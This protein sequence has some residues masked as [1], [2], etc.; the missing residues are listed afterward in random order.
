MSLFEFGKDEVEVPEVQDPNAWEFLSDNEDF[1]T[2]R[3]RVPGGWIVRTQKNVY[4]GG[5][6]ALVFVPDV[7]HTW[8]PK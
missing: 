4:H 5:G 1:A 6:E 3:R 2:H 8:R 7:D